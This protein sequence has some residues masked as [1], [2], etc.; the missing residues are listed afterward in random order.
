LVSKNSDHFFSE[1]LL[2][3]SITED[4]TCTSCSAKEGPVHNCGCQRQTNRSL[5]LLLNVSQTEIQVVG[6]TNRIARPYSDPPTVERNMLSRETLASLVAP[7]GDNP[8][9]EP[10]VGGVLL[11]DNPPQSLTAATQAHTGY[12][13]FTDIESYKLD[14]E[15]T[16]IILYILLCMRNLKSVTSRTFPSFYTTY[17]TDK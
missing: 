8:P 3:S 11:G 13:S 15:L 1:P 14:D 17:C 4:L 5:D 10:R 16:Y 12:S 6:N 7:W 2:L 9:S